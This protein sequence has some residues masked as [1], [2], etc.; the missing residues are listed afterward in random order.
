MILKL[1]K[2]FKNKSPFTGFEPYDIFDYLA[3][4]NQTVSS[5]T[6]FY[7]GFCMPKFTKSLA[8]EFF[9]NRLKQS[10]VIL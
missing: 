9:L 10:L 6:P 7:L 1:S 3:F 8:Y 4:N 5:E 2:N